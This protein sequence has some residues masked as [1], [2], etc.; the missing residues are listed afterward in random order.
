VA[1]GEGEY[2]GEGGRRSDASIQRWGSGSSSIIEAHGGGTFLVSPAVDA[3]GAEV[4]YVWHEV[5]RQQSGQGRSPGPSGSATL[6]KLKGR[7]STV[8]HTIPIGFET[9]T[10]PAVR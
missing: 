9:G 10:K 7:Q 8:R 4:E 2:V 6:H 5:V 3:C 1:G